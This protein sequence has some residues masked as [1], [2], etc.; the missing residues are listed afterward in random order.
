MKNKSLAKKKVGTYKGNCKYKKSLIL[1]CK[2]SS[3]VNK[4]LCQLRSVVNFK[5][6][7][8]IIISFNS[9]I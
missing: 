5:H 8:G 2:K 9:I 4:G 6:N 1:T 3:V 7:S